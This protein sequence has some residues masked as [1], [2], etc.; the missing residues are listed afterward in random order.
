MKK[1]FTVKEANLMADDMAEKMGLNK[2]LMR[3]SVTTLHKAGVV[4]EDTHGET[5]YCDDCQ[6]RLND[7]GKHIDC[8]TCNSTGIKP[9]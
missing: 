4:L 6:G 2:T 3:K 1:K 7:Q 8:R 9:S 5:M